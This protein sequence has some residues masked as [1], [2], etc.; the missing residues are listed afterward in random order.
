MPKMNINVTI[1]VSLILDL[2][3]FT[4]IL[5]LLPSTLECFSKNDVVRIAQLASSNQHSVF[6][7]QSGLYGYIEAFILSGQSLM[8]SPEKF[9]KGTL[10]WHVTLA[11]LLLLRLIFTALFGGLL[12]SWFSLLQFITM[13]IVG[14]LSDV[15][16][17]RI[18]YL[19]CLAG[20]S[21]SY[22]LWNI[23]ANNFSIFVLFRTL[24]G[25]S[26]GNISL[27]TAIV[28]DTS[29]EDKR[30]KG[31]AL[32]GICFS[33]GFTV[34]LLK[35]LYYYSHLLFSSLGRCWAPWWQLALFVQLS[36][37]FSICHLWL[38]YFCLWPISH[39]L[40]FTYRK[41]FLLPEG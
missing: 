22:L 25:L 26:K 40:T 27:S 8:G 37:A 29:T 5:P 32:I 18:I 7:F 28:T 23:S 30:G 24:G 2:L 36:P 15:Y 10:Y 38:R 21:F 19:A 4:L 20:I 6:C 13:P 31:F 1:F 41:R 17:R 33:L 12:G 16:G 9:N 11:L 3:A 39:F 14:S 35:I 34:S